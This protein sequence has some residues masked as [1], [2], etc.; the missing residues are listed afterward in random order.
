MLAKVR[1]RRGA[2]AGHRGAQPGQRRVGFGSG[3]KTGQQALHLR[4]IFPLW[5][6]IEREV[7]TPQLAP[8]WDNKAT[9]KEVT[10]EI[11]AQTNRI[12]AGG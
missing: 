11:V 7:F 4:P 8:L 3:A 1:S 2:E 6:R 12:L 10:R 9:P 5:D